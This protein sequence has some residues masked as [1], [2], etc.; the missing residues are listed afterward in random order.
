MDYNLYF[1]PSGATGTVFVWNGKTY[2]GITVYQTR[3]GK[4]GNAKFADPLEHDHT[5]LARPINFTGSQR[6]H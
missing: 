4:D 2:T 3:T 5:R 1:S 6:W